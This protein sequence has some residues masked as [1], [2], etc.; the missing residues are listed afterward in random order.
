MLLSV[1]LPSNRP[2]FFR[3]LAASLAETASDRRNFE[4]IVK[5]DEGDGGMAAEVDALRR[6]LGIAISA[7]VSPPPRDYFDISR[8][9][10]DT[11]AVADPSAYFCWHVN[12][13][14]IVETPGW[15]ELLQRY[16]G[17]FK[18]DLFRLKISP[19]KMFRTILD[20]HEV[21]LYGDFPITTKRWLEL[22]D[23]WVRGHGAEPY[24][25]GIAFLLAQ[26]GV[27]RNIPLPDFRIGGD[28]PGR[29]MDTA[30]ATLR[31]RGTC[32]HWDQNMGPELREMMTICARRIELCVTAGVMG[33]SG[34][35]LQR[36]EPAK[37]ISLVAADGSVASRVWYQIDPL[38]IRWE[39]LK[40]VA[41]RNQ[42]VWPFS[43]WGKPWWYRV[44]VYCFR[45]ADQLRRGLF[46]TVYLPIAA[47][48]GAPIRCWWAQDLERQIVRH[49]QLLMRIGDL[50]S[51]CTPRI[52]RFLV[53]R[54]EALRR[55]GW[56]T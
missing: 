26:R 35:T 19:G 20:I 44:L 46:L 10:N 49:W 16:K 42:Q 13:E 40:V 1:Q 43:V 41:R 30:R 7:V 12:D 18:D 28:E 4:L 8:F 25:E 48:F 50:S 24:Q 55:R 15:D 22:T 38:R 11:L 9:C 21:N 39:N 29:N 52:H 3:R 31:D 36:N 2:F 32:F 53:S 51:R 6:D 17:F 27:H 34:Y 23:G 14:V 54:I 33:L 5:I 45:S 47:L 56:L 37:C